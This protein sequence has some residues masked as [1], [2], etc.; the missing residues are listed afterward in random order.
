MNSE[1]IGGGIVDLEVTFLAKLNECSRMA[2][3]KRV[4]DYK[5]FC[6]DNNLV[7][8]EPSSAMMMSYWTIKAIILSAASS[9]Q[10][11]QKEVSPNNNSTSNSNVYNYSFNNGTV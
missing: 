9:S 10:L 11:A 4:A 6:E 1:R 2:Y 7:N 8:T 3:R 5:L